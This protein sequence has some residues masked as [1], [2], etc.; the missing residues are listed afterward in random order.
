[1]MVV[2]EMHLP[3]IFS[4]DENNTMF[5]WVFPKLLYLL[6]RDYFATLQHST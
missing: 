4:L 5:R 1:M 3:A 2:L 6:P